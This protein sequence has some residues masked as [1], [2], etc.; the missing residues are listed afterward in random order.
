M[1]DQVKLIRIHIYNLFKF[2]KSVTVEYVLFSMLMV[3]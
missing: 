1:P 2:N 3:F